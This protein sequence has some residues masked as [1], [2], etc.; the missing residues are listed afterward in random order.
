MAKK[1]KY[2]ICRCEESFCK[3]VMDEPTSPDECVIFSPNTNWKEVSKKD[4]EKE[5]A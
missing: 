2:Y 5:T 4:F 3:A 1:K